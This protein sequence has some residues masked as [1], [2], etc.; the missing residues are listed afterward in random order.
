MVDGD[1]KCTFLLLA[2][3]NFNKPYPHFHFN[4]IEIVI[5]LA[6]HTYEV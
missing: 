5:P 6:V 3:D 4:E 1:G 2:S